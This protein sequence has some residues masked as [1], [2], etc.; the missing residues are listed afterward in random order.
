MHCACCEKYPTAAN[1]GK[2]C[3]SCV[4]FHIQIH[5]ETALGWNKKKTWFHFNTFTLYFFVK[6]HTDGQLNAVWHFFK[7]YTLHQVCGV[8][9]KTEGK[10]N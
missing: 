7:H 6:W 9:S 10:L 2:S 5:G 8:A 3:F 4:H 1:G